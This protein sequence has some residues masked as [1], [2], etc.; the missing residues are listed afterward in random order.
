MTS[1]LRFA[2]CGALLALPQAQAQVSTYQAA[3]GTLTIPSVAVGTATFAN[4]TLV[5]TGGYR[6]ALQAASERQA[7]APA[8]AKFD[9]ATGLVTLPAVQ[10]GATTYLDV[11]LSHVGDYVFTLAGASLLPPT[12]LDEISAFLAGYD[13]LW[14]NAVP[15][16]AAMVA[17][18]DACYL[19]GGMTRD[20]VRQDREANAAEIAQRDAYRVGRK[21]SNIQ[22]L[23]QRR[24]T[25]GDGSTRT[26]VDVQYDIAFRDGSAEVGARTTLIK[27]SSA[28][29][30]GCALRQDE[31]QWRFYGDRLL[32]TKG[33]QARNSRDE[34][35]TLASGAAATPPLNYRRDIRFYISDPMGN[36]TYVVVEG[37]GPTATNGST[38]H[39]F[40][41]KLVSPRVMRGAPEFAGKT[42][43]FLNWEDDGNFRMCRV[44]GSGIAVAPL[45]DCTGLGASG[46]NVGTTSAT[47]DAAADAAFAALGFVAGGTYVVSV[48]N[49]DGWKTVNGHAGRTPIAVYDLTLEV[50][51]YSF[52]EM[53]G[54]GPAAD[55]FPRM[56]FGSATPAQ[57]QAQLVAASPT[58][59]AASWAAFDTAS[60]GAVMRLF[61]LGEYFQ[62]PKTGNAGT[63]SYPGYRVYMP[64]YPGSTATSVAA[65]PVT[66]KLT[67]MSKKTYAEFTLTL[68]DRKQRRVR[69]VVSF[70]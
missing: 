9:P 66:P 51:P 57:V 56:S 27:G 61:E 16:A 65:L 68:T 38:T 37:P 70:N 43:N 19:G 58:P 8:V 46:D 30:S 54:S 31:D 62:G 17:G 34:R 7:N 12:T 40:S 24:I 41:L 39:P 42:G 3:T 47:P 13:Q 32:L 10:V 26:E 52:V 69:S 48:Y 44:S 45:A 22:V 49:D 55:R 6:F 67:E 29:S 63:A 1:K 11:T 60:D 35:Y 53:A 15:G 25:N 64:T 21:T 20:Y 59:L 36:A 14:A 33:L 4:V 50:L 5:D 2:L 18:F 23:A 28:G